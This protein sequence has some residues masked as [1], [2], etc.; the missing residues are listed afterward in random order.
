MLAD[1]L[2]AGDHPAVAVTQLLLKEQTESVLATLS[3]REMRVIRGRI[4]GETQKQLAA[5]LR[6]TI[7]RSRQIEC[8][9]FR[10]LRHPSRAMALKDYW[11]D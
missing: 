6:V 10:K 3:A 9:S 11:D 4:T 8:E 5:E 2:T 7:R 1:I